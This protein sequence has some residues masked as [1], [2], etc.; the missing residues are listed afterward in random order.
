MRPPGVRR[1]HIAA[2]LAVW[3]DFPSAGRQRQ[4]AGLASDGGLRWQS[5]IQ[6]AVLAVLEISN[7]ILNIKPSGVKEHAMPL[8]PGHISPDSS[9][10][11]PIFSLST[12][13]VSLVSSLVKHHPGLLL[14]F[15]P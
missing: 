11:I 2:V 10:F 8:V 12:H 9:L 13:V 7:Q 14:F 3:R 5:A 4:I 6:G 15:C 1:N